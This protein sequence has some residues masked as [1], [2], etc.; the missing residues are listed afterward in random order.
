M[1][2]KAIKRKNVRRTIYENEIYINKST[3]MNI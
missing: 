1:I 2:I 3:R